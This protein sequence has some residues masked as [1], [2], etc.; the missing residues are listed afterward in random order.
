MQSWFDEIERKLRNVDYLYKIK[1]ES[2]DSWIGFEMEERNKQIIE[3]YELH[4]GVLSWMYVQINWKTDWDRVECTKMK[5]GY[6]FFYR[7]L[8]FFPSVIY[9]NNFIKKEKLKFKIY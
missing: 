3:Q 1:S 8:L 6:N 4:Y 9:V 2:R 5:W 7:K